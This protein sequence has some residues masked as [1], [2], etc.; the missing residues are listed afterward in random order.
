MGFP[1]MLALRAVQGVFAVVILGLSAYGKDPW[2][3]DGLGNWAKQDH[4]ANSAQQ[5]P[6]GTMSTP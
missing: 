4:S 2:I 1:L 3:E 5:L 6:T